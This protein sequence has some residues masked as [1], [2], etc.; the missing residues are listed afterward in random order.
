MGATSHCLRSKPTH[1]NIKIIRQT[2]RSSQERL[3]SLSLSSIYDTYSYETKD[4]YYDMPSCTSAGLFTTYISTTIIRRA[5]CNA[6]LTKRPT[7]IKN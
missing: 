7:D 5:T 4:R 2:I 1:P 3:I 6:L